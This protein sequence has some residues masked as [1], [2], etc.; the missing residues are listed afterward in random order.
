M[1]KKREEIQ[2]KL[3]NG[4]IKLPSLNSATIEAIEVG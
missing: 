1:E 4:T 3:L 2:E